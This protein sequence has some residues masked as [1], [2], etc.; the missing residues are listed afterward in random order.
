MYLH[1]YIDF[2]LLS[3]LHKRWWLVRMDYSNKGCNLSSSRVKRSF[4]L[5]FKHILR[6]FRQSEEKVDTNTRGGASV[7]L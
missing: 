2:F 4:E 3:D 6:K 7:N 1:M 5:I